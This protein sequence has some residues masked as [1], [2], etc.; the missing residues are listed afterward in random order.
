MT[1]Y[2]LLL[3]SRDCLSGQLSPLD[4]YDPENR[5]ARMLVHSYGHRTDLELWQDQERTEP[6][7]PMN[8]DR[9]WWL[10]E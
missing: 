5:S 9:P 8:D 1:C 2:R 4:L 10:P 7:P 6:L 3:A